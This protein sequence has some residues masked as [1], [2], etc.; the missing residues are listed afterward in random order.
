MDSGRYLT[1]LEPAS[2]EL[3]KQ[4]YSG[5]SEV[6]KKAYLKYISSFLTLCGEAKEEAQKTHRIFLPSK[7]S[8]PMLHLPLRNNMIREKLIISTP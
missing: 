6:Q 8:F 1:L 5:E 7:N 2:A 4:V 3:T